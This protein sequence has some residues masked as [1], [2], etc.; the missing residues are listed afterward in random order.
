MPKKKQN[1]GI[2]STT[3]SSHELINHLNRIINIQDRLHDSNLKVDTFIRTAAEQVQN[4]TKAAGASIELVEGDNLV[5]KA[6]TGSMEKLIGKIID[7]NISISGLCI[8]THQIIRSDD[9]END[10]RM[11]NQEIKQLQAKSMIITPF[12]YAKGAAGVVKIISSRLNAFSD[13]D[14]QTIRII[15]GLIGEAINQQIMQTEMEQ[16]NEEKTHALDDL[17]KSEKKIKHISRHDYLTNLPNRNFFN[18]QLELTLAKAKRKKQLIAIMYLDIDQFKDVN[19]TMGHSYGD[20]VLIAFANRLKQCMRASD[21]AARFGGDEFIV[22][23]DDIKEVQDAIVISNKILQAM[24]QPFTISNKPVVLT[25]SIGIAFLRDSDISPD[26]FIR[27]AD[28]AL[29]VSKN[30]G[31]NTFYIYDNDLTVEHTPTNSG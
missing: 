9:M 31:R 20:K 10:P 13:I 5:Y 27:Q 25:T 14:I 22:L 3:L 11:D 16:I 21:V 15:A 1:Q 28:Q 29:Y 17:K 23:V 19:D 7:K 26:D 30:S 2:K 6:A 12:F 8:S 24:R 4:L 18:D